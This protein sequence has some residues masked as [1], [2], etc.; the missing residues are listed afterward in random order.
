MAQDNSERRVPS[1]HNYNISQVVVFFS[2]LPMDFFLLAISPLGV[3]FQGKINLVELDANLIPHVLSG[4]IAFKF[5]ISHF[6]Y[7]TS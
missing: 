4:R 7:S 1:F 5:L 3:E 2:L 6:A